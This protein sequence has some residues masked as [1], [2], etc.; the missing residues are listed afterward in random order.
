MKH[1]HRAN[2]T[3]AAET[4]GDALHRLRADLDGRAPPAAV[5]GAVLARLQP[6][7]ALALAQGGGGRSA[8]W[9]PWATAALC[10]ALLVLGTVLALRTPSHAV[11]AAGVM[12]DLAGAGFVP[13]AAA[14]RWPTSTAPAAPAWLVRA[15]LPNE[16][17]A[18]FGLPFDPT[19]AGET[20]R[21]ELLMRAS[22][23]VLAVRVL[24]DA[25]PR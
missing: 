21:T 16:R 8:A 14:E 17:L 22:G 7:H 6:A 24:A 20:V 10:G 5:R 11:H 19:R 3:P 25:S 23:E 18:E 12:A 15:E 4:L 9:A 13:V 1:E 2:E